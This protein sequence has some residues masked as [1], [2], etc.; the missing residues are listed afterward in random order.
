MKKRLFFM[1]F[2]L[3]FMFPYVVNA[4]GVTSYVE[5]GGMSIPAPLTTITRTVF[6]LLQILVPIG[7]VVMGSLDFLKATIASDSDKMKKSQKKFISRLTAGAITF[8]VFVIVRLVINMVDSN[9]GTESNYA[10]CLKCLLSS[11]DGCN[12]VSET[13]FDSSTPSSGDKEEGSDSKEN[14]GESLYISNLTNDGVIVSIE[15]TS[16]SKIVA[17]YF[18]YNSTR[19]DKNNGGYLATDKKEFDVVRLPGTTYVWVEDE[20]GNISKSK[21]ITLTN[22]VLPVTTGSSYKTLKDIKL[23]T[24]LKNKGWSLNELNKLIARSVRAAGLYS[25]EAAA[26]SG[27][28]LFS[29][30]AQKYKI[31]LP[32]YNGGKSW[33]YG[34]NGDWGKYKVRTTKRG[35]YYYMALDCSGFATWAYVNAGYNI[36]RKSDNKYP[37]FFWGWYKKTVPLKKENG[38]IG[39]FLVTDH[40]VKVIVGKTDKGFLAAE[41]GGKGMVISLHKYSNNKDYYIEKSSLLTKTYGKV[42]E[43]SYPSGF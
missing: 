30:L 10:N 1:M 9:V 25:N 31:K 18:S 37:A 13:P 14:S 40:H 41:A 24:Y 8:F 11:S 42:A 35:T 26:T 16:E 38:D 29:V 39:D 15:A 27:V 43:T 34:A 28:A 6:L 5:C 32:Y 36:S 3:F 12:T 4:A 22:S 21:S 2:T 20:N 17:Y 33:D 23:E 7:I 19:P